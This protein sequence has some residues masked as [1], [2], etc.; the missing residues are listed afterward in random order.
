MAVTGSTATD[1]SAPGAGGADR[2]TPAGGSL[3]R[4][5]RTPAP[6]PTAATWALVAGLVAVFVGERILHHL[7]A[8]RAIA[9][10]L[11]VATVLLMTAWRARSF[12]RQTGAARRVEG[13]LLAE[14]AGCLVAL[15]IYFLGALAVAPTHERLSTVLTIAWLV[16]LAASLI[17]LLVTQWT[18][19][20]GIDEAVEEVRVRDAAASGL[21]LALA[22]AF[23]LVL[24]FIVGERD[25]QVDVSYFRTASPGSATERTVKGMDQPLRVLLFFPEVNEVKS[26]VLGY[27]QALA[28]GTGGR[29][30]IEAHDRMAVPKLAKDHNVTR[31]G[32]IVLL[33]G[34]QSENMVIDTQMLGARTMLRTFDSEV[35]KSL[36]KIARGARVAYLTTGHG[37]MTDPPAPGAAPD[38]LVRASL[39]REILSSLNYRLSD[40]GLKSGLASDVPDD[41]TVVLVIGAK[42]PF[43]DQEIDALDRYLARGGSLL[44]AIDQAGEFRLGKLEQRL[45]V[46]FDATPLADDRAHLRLRNNA[47]D[48]R[49][50]VTD[51]FSS[52]A[53]VTTLARSRAGIGLVAPLAGSL[54]EVDMKALPEDQRPRRSYVVRSLPSTFADKNGNN[55]LDGDEKRASSNLAAAIEGGAAPEIAPGKDKP[56]AHPM[57]AMVLAAAPMLSDLLMERVPLNAALVADGI[58]WL[59]GEEQLAG[60][61]VSE[62]DVPIEHTRSTDQAWFYSTIIGAP[63]L[64]LGAGV[65]FTA[66]RRR[67]GRAK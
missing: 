26:E 35:Q 5:P 60:E 11:G 15:I 19:A 18:A 7:P 61:T 50:L 28:R 23:L 25:V 24:G 10:G 33:K 51:Q 62:R 37:E 39:V 47:S 4:E 56:A 58:K 67:A 3:G 57:R 21:T 64:V 41:A 12:A 46:S 49:L 29:V 6:P 31:D 2:A 52:H 42:Q 22:A 59:G 55:E 44:V 14:S 30:E 53:S 27:F 38:P 34:K 9:S 66:R 43:L 48:N 63:L 32:T 13:L 54:A 1:A 36:M 16:I 20:R 8:A 40:L 17:P 45:G 65:G